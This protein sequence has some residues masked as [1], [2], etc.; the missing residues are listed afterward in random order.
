[1]VHVRSWGLLSFSGFPVPDE[2]REQLPP[3]PPSERFGS[4]KCNILGFDIET[5]LEKLKIHFTS[6][7]L[8]TPE[9]RY[10]Y[11]VYTPRRNHLF[12]RP[13]AA[14]SET[15]EASAFAAKMSFTSRDS[16]SCK[17]CIH[18]SKE[19]TKNSA[20]T[21]TILFYGIYRQYPLTPAAV[22]AGGARQGKWVFFSLWWK[23]F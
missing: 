3:P 7:S 13:R 16:S 1:M 8:L 11:T 9:T 2:L 18:H 22:A 17:C 5:L 4:H 21:F 10:W 20:D 6:S 15:Y 12:C 23:V 19:E 14:C